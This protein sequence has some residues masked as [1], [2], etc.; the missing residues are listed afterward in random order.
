MDNKKKLLVLQYI[1]LGLFILTGII[2]AITEKN[3]GAFSV[4]IPG[5][6][7]NI[8]CIVHLTKDKK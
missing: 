6:A 7:A 4:C 1:S 8:A 3:A 2:W 5:A